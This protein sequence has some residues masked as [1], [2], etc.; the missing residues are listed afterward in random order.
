ML[1]YTVFHTIAWPGPYAWYFFVIGISVAL[2]FFSALSWYR[3]EFRPLR[4]SAFYLSFGLLVLGGLLL[5]GDLSQPMRFLNMVNPAYLNFDSPLAWGSLNLVA[6]GLVSVVYF[7]FLRKGEQVNAK[8]L[9]VAG[10]LLGLGLPIYTGFDL[11][12]HQHRAVWNTPL[13]PV[14]FVSLSLV[15]GAAVASFLAKGP[16]KL[17]S[18]LRS[19]MLWG[20]GA[21]AAMLVSLLGTT[22]YGGSGSEVTFMFMTS[23]TMGLIFIGLGMVV[24]LAAPIALLLAPVGRQPIGIMAAGGLLLVGGM[25]LR[26]AILIGPQIVHT[27]Y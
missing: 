15:S 5:I 3:E 11:T 9:A 7:V 6:F 16:E 14:L 24:G 4:H 23:G 8:R 17:V 18:M 2:F 21:T 19:F 26:Y 25:A 13:M 12:V 22:A 27:Y 20:G 10:A 1:D